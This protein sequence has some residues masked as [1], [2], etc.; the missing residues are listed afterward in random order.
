MLSGCEDLDTLS[1][2]LGT[3]PRVDRIAIYGNADV[4]DLSQ[5]VELLGL[6]DESIPLQVGVSSIE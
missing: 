2:L 3:Q 6:E 1:I 4:N 5:W